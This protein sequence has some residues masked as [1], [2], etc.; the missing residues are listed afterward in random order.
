MT[1]LDGMRIFLYRTD[2]DS[3]GW[4]DVISLWL[5]RQ[6]VIYK[7]LKRIKLSN[8]IFNRNTAIVFYR[9]RRFFAPSLRR[10]A[11]RLS[12]YQTPSL[13]ESPRSSLSRL[14]LIYPFSR[15]GANRNS[16]PLRSF[17]STSSLS[18]LAKAFQLCARRYFVSNPI[19]VVPLSALFVLFLFRS[20]AIHVFDFFSPQL[21]VLR[22]RL[23]TT[24]RI[25]RLFLFR[26]LTFDEVAVI[27]FSTS[28]MKEMNVFFFFSRKILCCVFFVFSLENTKTWRKNRRRRRRRRLCEGERRANGEWTPPRPKST[29][30]TKTTTSVVVVV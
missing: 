3:G 11:V 10:K 9:R 18:L 29:T 13:D 7:H 8:A 27:G 12:S 4:L 26:W 21:P 24:C 25:D 20:R 14:C 19:L 16:P 23:R 22:A 1:R 30:T 5:Q 28:K 15:S 6:N 17:L 2:V